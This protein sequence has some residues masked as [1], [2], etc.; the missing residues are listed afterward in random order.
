MRFRSKFIFLAMDVWLL[1]CH[2]VKTMKPFPIKLS[3]HLFQKSVGHIYL[4]LFFSYSVVSNSLWC[5]GLQ[6][7]R[8]PCPS[9]SL[10]VCSNSCPSNQWCHSTISSSVALFSSCSQ[11]FSVSGSFPVSQLFESGGQSIGALASAS[12]L[13]MNIQGWFPLGLTAWSPCS[14]RDS[15]RSSHAQF[16]SIN[17]SVLS[18]RYGP[19]LTSVHDYWKNHSLGYTNEY[20]CIIYPFP[21]IYVSLPP[22]I[23]SSWLTCLWYPLERGLRC[24]N[25]ALWAWKLKLPTIPLF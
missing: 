11:P 15:Q 7:T 1:Q 14:P 4:S 22:S 23:P 8:L 25:T 19:T 16:K 6:H 9:L 10:R 5:H 21:L 3:L 20:L 2:L 12:A 13:L 24:L 17:S 18:L